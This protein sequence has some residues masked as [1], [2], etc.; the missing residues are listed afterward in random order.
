MIE[1]LTQLDIQL[2]YWL[3]AAH[4][5]WLDPIMV[6]LTNKLTWIPAYLGLLSIIIRREYWK[7][8][9]LL[10]L[11]IAGLVTLTDQT[12]SSLLKPHVKRYRPCRVEAGLKF[13]VHT[14]NNKCGGKYGFASGHAAN[15][16]GLAM[17][18]SLFFGPKKWSLL[19]FTIASLVAYTR[20][21]LGVHY[22]GDVLAGAA[23]GILLG[24][25]VYAIYQKIQQAPLFASS[26]PQE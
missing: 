4:A 9:L 2:F 17:F 23:I 7:K 21:Y 24:L 22:P 14:V 26:S 15:F 18:L 10:L 13:E 20:I 5:D 11:C 16:F 12:T 3:N 1:F 8:V 19:F 25:L 6:F